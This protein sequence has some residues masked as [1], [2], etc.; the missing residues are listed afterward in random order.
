VCVCVC[1]C[2]CVYI[3]MCVCV[4]VCVCVRMCMCMHKY[5]CAYVCVCACVC[6]YVCTCVHIYAQCARV[7]MTSAASPCSPRG[8]EVRLLSAKFSRR[9][10]LSAS[11]HDTE[12]VVIPGSV[13]C[14]C[15]V[16]MLLLW[17]YYVV[18]AALLQCI[19]KSF[20]TVMLLLS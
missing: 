10:T 12:M 13:S 17:C 20:Y 16:M 14:S 3:Y 1:V 18:L 19:L 8:G 9:S 7:C 15:G 4:C 2:V 6:A 11:W 5:S